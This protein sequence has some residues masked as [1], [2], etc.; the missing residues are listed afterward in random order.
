VALKGMS[1]TGHVGFTLFQVS[2]FARYKARIGNVERAL[3]L[4]GLVL[5]HPATDSEINDHC[6]PLLD[7][8]TAELPSE[9]VE[10]A[11]ERGKSQ[12]L[13]DVVRE[14]LAQYRS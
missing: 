6:G 1:E 3:E 8:L 9:I 7:E 12:G 2:Q 14:L 13:D 4:L 5:N 10:A 11:M